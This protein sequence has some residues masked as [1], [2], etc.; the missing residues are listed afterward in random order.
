MGVGQMGGGG[1]S[2]SIDDSRWR[3]EQFSLRRRSLSYFRGSAMMIN[4]IF[5][6][7]EWCWMCGVRHFPNSLSSGILAHAG[8]INLF[9]A[10]RFGK[11]RKTC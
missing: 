5:P 3:Y 8:S 4:R 10:G 1:E 2:F 9:A 7:A 11:I 6:S